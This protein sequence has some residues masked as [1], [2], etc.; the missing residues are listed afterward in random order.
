VIAIFGLELTI[1]MGGPEIGGYSKWLDEHV[2]ISPLYFG[3]NAP[4][5]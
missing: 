5:S 4:Q 3:K 2:N 1:N